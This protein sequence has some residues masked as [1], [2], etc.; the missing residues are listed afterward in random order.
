M[1]ATSVVPLIRATF[2][3]PGEGDMLWGTA[4]MLP[5]SSLE[6]ALRACRRPGVAWGTRV[7]EDRI[8]FSLR[9]GAAE[10]RAAFLAALVA[11]VGAT[12]IR[13]GDTRPSLL[14]TE[15]LLARGA[16]L[17]TAESC[18]GGLVAKYL[19]DLPGSSRVIWGGWIAYANA[20]KER[21]RAE[22]A[23]PVFAAPSGADPTRRWTLVVRYA[24][25]GLLTVDRQVTPLWQD[26]VV[27]DDV[28]MISADPDVTTIQSLA[29][30]MQ[31][32]RGSQQSDTS[33]SRRATLL[34]PAGAIPPA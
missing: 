1:F 33:G 32:A 9:G 20:A 8:I 5:E 14:L 3:A 21:L 34:F 17:V 28:V 2:G 31:V 25:P 30:T 24:A 16:T 26:W 6:E 18:T 11:R 15:A 29:T 4:L 27:V 22:A 19:T 7:E 23:P 13:A 10:E 12:R